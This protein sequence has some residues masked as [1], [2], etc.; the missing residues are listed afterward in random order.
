MQITNVR[1]GAG[2]G[3][4]ACFDLEHDGFHIYD[5]AL[6]RNGAGELR[7]FAPSPN[8]RRIVTFDRALVDQIISNYE[9]SNGS[10]SAHGAIRN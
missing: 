4:I 6:R 2:Q 7:V 3:L 5:V 8:S 1:H 9:S 10:L